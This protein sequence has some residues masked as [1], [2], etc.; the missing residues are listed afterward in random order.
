MFCFSANLSNL[1]LIFSKLVDFCSKILLVVMIISNLLFNSSI[2]SSFCLIVISFSTIILVYLFST[3]LIL[4]LIS[5]LDKDLNS[6][7]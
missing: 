4:L 3:S 5:S 2:L 1:L 6:L 7:L